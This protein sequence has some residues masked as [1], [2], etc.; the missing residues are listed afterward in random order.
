[1]IKAGD[2]IVRK[3]DGKKLGRISSYH[4]EIEYDLSKSE[5]T[6][7]DMED[8]TN[9]LLHEII[10]EEQAKLISEG[11]A[12]NRRVKMIFC[13]RDEATHV[14]F[15]GVCGGH[16]AIA[17]VEVVGQCDWTEERFVEQHKR[18]EAFANERINLT[19]THWNWV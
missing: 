6:G 9:E 1:M 8:F 4:K 12:A 16:A 11:K 19:K 18:A 3:S 5:V 14:S 10:L 17:E 7:D 2:I 15:S 13:K